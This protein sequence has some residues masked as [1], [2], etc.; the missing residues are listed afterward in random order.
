MDLMKF[1]CHRNKKR[2]IKIKD[3]YFPV[4]ARCTGFY[5]AILLYPIFS[6]LLHFQ[7]NFYSKLIAILLL[8]P[9][10]F[11]GVTQF[12]KLRESNNM[13]RLIT[14]ILGG[15]GVDILLF[16]IFNSVHFINF[17]NF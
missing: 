3:S 4:C 6:I 16:N 11:D 13:L 17:I 5:L 7:Y 14:G 15:I 2:T 9:M 1:V 10:I 8:L 12:F